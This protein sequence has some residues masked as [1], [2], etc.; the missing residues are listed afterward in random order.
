MHIHTYIINTHTHTHT[1]K[2]V[3]IHG[4]LNPLSLS[5]ADGIKVNPDK[6][7]KYSPFIIIQIYTYIRECVSV[8]FNVMFTYVDTYIWMISI[9]STYFYMGLI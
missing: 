3:S 8:L 1:G 6:G 4:R 7:I 2:H 9:Y 5:P